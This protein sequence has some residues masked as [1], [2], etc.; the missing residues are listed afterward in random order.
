MPL[1]RD[2]VVREVPSKS[3]ARMAI[4]RAAMETLEER[5]L[6]AGVVINEFLADN[7]TGIVDEDNTHSDWIELRNTNATSTNLAG[8]SLTDDAADLDKWVFP[9]VSIPAG[10]YLLVWASGKNRAVAGQD[11]RSHRLR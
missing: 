9:S 7:S 11:G 8:W 1:R 4:V 10:G 2:H 5:R 3:A 6:F